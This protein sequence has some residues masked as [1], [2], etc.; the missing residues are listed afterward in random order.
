MISPWLGEVEWDSASELFF[1]SGLPGFENERHMVPVEIP[2]RR[3]LVYL[4]SA[5]NAG[6]CFVCLPAPAIDPAFVLQISEEEKAALQL[7]ADS[8]AGIGVDVLCLGLLMPVEKTVQ[9]NLGSPVVINLH[10]GRGVQR[11][12]DDRS[13]S[14]FRLGDNGEW[15]RLC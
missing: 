10:N 3:P 4:Q 1:P 9:V 15:N 14:R 7:S 6:L 2:A 13:V 8:V 12:P 11:I 5:Q